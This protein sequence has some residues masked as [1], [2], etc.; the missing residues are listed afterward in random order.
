M[1]FLMQFV[2]ADSHSDA[3]SHDIFGPIRSLSN[4]NQIGAKLN[5]DLD[6]R[7]KFQKK[8]PA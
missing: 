6:N 7:T 3:Y 8:S 4:T 2:D 5:S 1:I